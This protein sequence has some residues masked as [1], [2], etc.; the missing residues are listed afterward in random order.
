M[1]RRIVLHVGSPKCGSTF[2]QKTLLRNRKVLASHGVAYPHDGGAHPGNAAPLGQLDRATYDGFF[3]GGMHTVI[4]SHE[5]LYSTSRRGAS[6][7]EMVRQDGAQ[8][9]LLAFIRPFSEF[10]F[11]DYSQFMKQFFEQFLQD[12]RPYGGQSFDEFALRRVISLKPATF[13]NRWRAQMG[14]APLTLGSHKAIRTVVT[15]LLGADVELNWELPRHQSNP[16]LRIID[17]DHIA[18]AMRDGK[19]DDQTIR[20]M[21]RAA[22]Y[23]TDNPDPGRSES[24]IRLI[25]SAFAPQNAALKDAF[26][27]DN[28]LSGLTL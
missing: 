25:E 12:R 3:E 5:D 24:R 22:F 14:G 10:V 2:L 28:T 4:L 26:G 19:T 1:S 11:G 6:L 17:C 21:F 9:R 7:A 18:E 8:L 16:S 23:Q 13:L 15:D 20:K 27:Y